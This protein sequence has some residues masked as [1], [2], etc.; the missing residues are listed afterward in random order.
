MGKLSRR[1]LA[2]LVEEATVD[3]YDEHEE[4]SALFTAVEENLAVPFS[5]SVLGAE[6]TVR[7]IDLSLDG[8]I[9]ALCTRGEFRQT[10]GLLDLQLPEP[11]PDGA[12]W[13]EAYR[14]YWTQ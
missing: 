11:A 10:I 5:T 13:V 3:T 6:V 14:Y 9:V 2:A 4:L 12:E 7:G 8:R 1:E